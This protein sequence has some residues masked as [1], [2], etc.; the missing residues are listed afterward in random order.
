MSGLAAGI[1]DVGEGQVQQMIDR[2]GHRGPD[3]SG[4]FKLSGLALA[5][6]YLRADI[7]PDYRDAAVPAVDTDG[8]ALGIAYD[9]EIGNRL[10]LCRTFG[11]DAGPL[12][13][14]RLLLKMLRAEG[15]Q[16]LG[17]LKD[18]VFAFVIAGSGE[19]VAAR[20]LLGI[21]TLFYGKKNGALFFASELKGILAVTDDVHEFPA[22]HVMDETGALIAFAALPDKA[23]E[24]WET[25]EDRAVGEV[26]RIIEDSFQ[27][28]VDFSFDTG[29]LL[30]G[31]IDSSVVAMLGSRET[32]RRFGQAARIKTF[33][34]GMGK[35]ED[36]VAARKV[37]EAIDAEHHEMIVD[38]EEAL[39]VI[40]EVV[41]HLESFDPSL[42]R[43]AVSNYLISRYARQ[44]GVEVLLS[45]EGGDEV[46][47]GYLYLKEKPAEA[48]F[49]GQVECL[50]LLHNNAALR[51][52]RMNRCNG[53][54]VVTPLISGE[55]LDY[56]LG[57]APA[58]KQKPE[59]GGKTEKW[60]FRKA[61]ENDLPGEV[62]WRLKQ[63]F[64]QGSGSAALLPAH[65]ESVVSDE[66]LAAAQRIHPIVRS[67]E[68]LA[69]FRIFTENFGD[70][71]AVAT[72]GQWVS[73]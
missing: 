23:P 2:M 19:F 43:S 53:V 71:P 44:H 47:C 9:G 29:S 11:V 30:S 50:K 6:N 52:D 18:A 16:A 22:G 28:R 3:R 40:P 7:G 63:E 31:G 34:L 27:R 20:D 14:E 12:E 32:K 33:A 26:R 73:L 36:I 10:A 21:K 39:A 24:R 54:R 72:V 17:R 66:E 25:H 57:L 59:A 45:G 35:S 5:Q 64:S 48:L 41:Y 49:A 1:G 4:V 13:E 42:V 70:G 69:Y 46:F 37:A 61:F 15:R 58:L 67:K 38:L 65:F 68:E 55:L 62:V 56:A 51:L 8:E 60:V